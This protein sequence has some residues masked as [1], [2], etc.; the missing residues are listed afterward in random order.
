MRRHDR[1]CYDDDGGFPGRSEKRFA[2]E[3]SLMQIAE[4]F[5]QIDGYEFSGT[6]GFSRAS[7]RGLAV[8]VAMDGTEART[9]LTLDQVRGI[10]PAVPW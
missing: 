8:D 3:G 7:T 9:D 10:V 6:T 4:K 2:E 1:E 5:Y